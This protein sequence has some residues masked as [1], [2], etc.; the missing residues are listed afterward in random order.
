MSAERNTSPFGLPSSRSSATL[1]ACL[2][3]GSECSCC[4]KLKQGSFSAAGADTE[5]ERST[6]ITRRKLFTYS[7]AYEEWLPGVSLNSSRLA[8][9]PKSTSAEEF[10]CTMTYIKVFDP[11]TCSFEG[12]EL[13]NFKLFWPQT[14]SPWNWRRHENGILYRRRN[15][16]ETTIINHKGTRMVKNRQD[17]CESPS[18]SLHISEGSG[19]K[20]YVQRYQKLTYCSGYS[21][22]FLFLVFRSKHGP[23]NITR[24]WTLEWRTRSSTYNNV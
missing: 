20:Q 4:M 9:N 24:S 11:H 12:A 21:N 14:K 2:P 7:R 1:E 23:W 3:G 8:W 13:R 6:G 22:F 19:L 15:I 18:L 16:R 5:Q 17:F 10:S